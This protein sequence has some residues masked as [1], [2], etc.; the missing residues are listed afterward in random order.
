MVK[1]CDDNNWS[2]APKYAA[3]F[4]IPV[5]KPDENADDKN[6]KGG[7]DKGK[8]DEKK[9]DKG[10]GK[11]KKKGAQDE[12]EIIVKGPSELV[13]KIYDLTSKFQKDWGEEEDNFE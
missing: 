12:D 5:A 4:Y 1:V 7:K 13:T 11:D 8:K 2:K 3:E 6:K 9:P 10:K